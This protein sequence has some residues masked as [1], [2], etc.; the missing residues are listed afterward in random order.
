MTGPERLPQWNPE[1]AE[2]CVVGCMVASYAGTSYA[3]SSGILP[4][5]FYDPRLG[6]LCAAALKHGGQDPV[7]SEARIERIAEMAGEHWSYVADLVNARPVMFDANH[8]HA[9]AVMAAASHRRTVRLM[10]SLVE[11]W[12]YRVELVPDHGQ[13]AA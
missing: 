6:R 7:D 9:E 12:G 5:D 2:R 8:A 4:A 11:S 1:G 13:V 10:F 3:R